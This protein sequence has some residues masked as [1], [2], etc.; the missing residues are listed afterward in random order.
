VAFTSH[1]GGMPVSA[2]V[3]G[4]LDSKNEKSWFHGRRP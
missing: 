2:L 1:H 4:R 3:M